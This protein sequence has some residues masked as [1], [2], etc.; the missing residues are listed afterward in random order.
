M[1]IKRLCIL[2]VTTTILFVPN[3]Y[4]AN[5]PSP[6]KLSSITKR[7]TRLYI[8]Y[9]DINGKLIRSIDKRKKMV[10]LTYDDGP[11]KYTKQ[12]LNTLDK[13]NSV[14]T[15]FVIGNQVSDY[16]NSVKAAYN[17][18]CE[19]GNHTFDHKLLTDLSASEI[20]YQISETNLAVKNC[21][22][23]TPQIM[24]PPCGLNDCWTDN[25]I[26]MPLI[27]W[28]ID[29][30]DWKTLNPASTIEAVISNISDGDIIL[31]HDFYKETAIATETIVPYLIIK[32]IQLVTVSELA[33]CRN[34]TLE[35]KKLYLSFS[36]K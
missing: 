9:Y 3:I 1:N 17:L 25:N 35:N 24:R 4:L 30:L 26:N 36:N 6:P 31:M 23:L 34:I 13:Y 7:N 29:T 21:I 28:S 32:D 22:G 19:I 20:N 33:E 2:L 11:S 5:E 14:A 12:I 8:S 10:A 15:F 18:G 16:S 27:L